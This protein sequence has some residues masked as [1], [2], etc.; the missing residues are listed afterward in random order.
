MFNMDFLPVSREDMRD[1]GWYYYDFLLITGDAYVDHPSFGAAVIGRVLEA[2]GYRVAVLAQP[3]WKN[4]DAFTAMGRPRYAAL[5]GAGNLDSMVAHYTAAKKRRHDDAYSPG[6]RAGLRPDHA[7]IVYSNC[8][9][10]AF[11]GLPIVIGG[12]EASLRRFAHYDYWDDQV[13]RPVI[14]DAKAD[15]LVYGMGERATIEVAARLA[16]G[17]S[18]DSIRD[19]RGTG[20][21]TKNPGECAFPHV[22]C[23]SFE[24]VRDDKTAYA[25]SNMIQYDEHDPVRGK[26]IIQKCSGRY[27]VINPPQ[28]PLN[29]E[30][31]DR[32]SELPYM[33]AP[34]PMYDKMGGVP[35]IEEVRFSVI[36][37]RGCFGGCNFCSLA[38]HQGRMVTSRSHESVIR[39]VTELTKLPDFKG[40]I[41]DVGGPTANFRRP[42]CKMQ[43]KNGMC[44]GKNCLTPSPCKNVDADHTDYLL[45]LRKLRNIPGVKKVF[46]RSGIRFDYL[47]LDKKGEFFPELVKYHISGQLKVAPEHCI[48]SVLDYM[49]KPHNEVYNRFMEKY[50]SLNARYK[51][52]QYLVPYLI[53]SHP[54]STMK[55]AVALAEYLNKTGRQPEQVQDFYPTPGTISTCM[56]YTGIDPRTMKK[57]YVPKSFH[58]KAMQ[59]ALL[60]WKRPEKR[61]LV[62]EALRTAGRRDLIGYGKNCLIRPEKDRRQEN[63]GKKTEKKVG[64]SRPS[65]R[66]KTSRPR[67]KRK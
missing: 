63:L 30:E 27:L 11:P 6:R 41:H 47:L 29:T 15:I 20:F 24:K 32:V 57:V 9:R 40:Y 23:D 35:A 34:H 51:K 44:K 4:T 55:D 60:Q 33:R 17:E 56:Y 3:D 39:E 53:S 46:V 54:G 52:D 1:R 62:E 64:A 10:E 38:F 49:G 36:H 37:N 59:R 22:F 19:I 61:E 43:L 28:M 45:L 12:L 26:A 66:G 13:R 67:K 21:V 50:A 2:E 7:V 16:K 8:V 18:P 25:K 31:F 5:V 48:N 42:S 14:F 65:D 58:E